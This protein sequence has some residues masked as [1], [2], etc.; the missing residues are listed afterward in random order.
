[1]LKKVDY[2]AVPLDKLVAE[3][4]VTLNDKGKS[5]GAIAI[6]D[7]YDGTQT[8]KLLQPLLVQ[9]IQE[10]RKLCCDV[11]MV[12]HN[13]RDYHRTR[14]ILNQSTDFIMFPAMN[15]VAMIKLAE[16]YF[17]LDREQIQKY[18]K[19]M[20]IKHRFYYCVHKRFPKL[21]ITSDRVVQLK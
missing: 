21:L 11:I 8:G 9:T 6:F 12:S 15:R 16:S 10:G 14:T 17:D 3:D 7:D 13:P 5:N 1:M 20:H 18:I 4:L 2:E 19:D